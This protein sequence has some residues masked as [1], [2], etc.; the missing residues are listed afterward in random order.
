VFVAM[1]A[2]SALALV[3]TARLSG[4]TART[5]AINGSVEAFHRRLSHPGAA[6]DGTQ[7]PHLRVP[8]E[9]SRHRIRRTTVQRDLQER[10]VRR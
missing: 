10:I 3:V 1:M 6:T 7:I 5:Q 8:Y 4:S 9:V 2:F